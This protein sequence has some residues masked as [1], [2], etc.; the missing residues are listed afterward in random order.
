[1]PDAED[2]L[3]LA[4]GKFLGFEQQHDPDAGD[5]RQQTKRFKG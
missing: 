5:I 1:L 3:E 2:F 4:D